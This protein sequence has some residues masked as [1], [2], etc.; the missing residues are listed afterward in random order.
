MLI[1]LDIQSGEP[2]LVRWLLLGHRV[3]IDHIFGPVHDA[4]GLTG[5]EVLLQHIGQAGDSDAEEPDPPVRRPPT[6]ASGDRA[7]D[8]CAIRRAE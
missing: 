2:I 5:K 7:D 3:I 1:M 6:A 4:R 8:I